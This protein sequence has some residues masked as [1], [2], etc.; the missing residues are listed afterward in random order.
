MANYLTSRNL[1]IAAGI[2]IAFLSGR[3]TAN[4]DSTSAEDPQASEADQRPNSK[5]RATRRNHPKNS[6]HM[7][8]QGAGVASIKT[9]AQLNKILRENG[10]T[11]LGIAQ[12]ALA[13]MNSTELAVLAADLAATYSSDPPHHQ[14]IW[15]TFAQ[16]AKVDPKAALHFSK[17][18]NLPFYRAALRA[19][20]QAFAIDDPISALKEA[21][22]IKDP[23]LA[24]QFKA[25]ALAQMARQAP[26][27]WVTEILSDP[28]N[29]HVVSA[30]SYYIAQWFK[31]DP[32]AALIR[33]KQL[34]PHLLQNAHSQI[35]SAWASKD[36]SAAMEWVSTLTN[37]QTRN[38][39]LTAVVSV[40]AKEQPDKAMELISEMPPGTR[41]TALASI[42]KTMATSDAMGAFN[43][44][45]SLTKSG[46][47]FTALSSILN[48]DG[49][50]FSSSR[51]GSNSGLYIGNHHSMFDMEQLQSI[52]SQLPSGQL[53][54]AALV[55][56]TP[57]LMGSSNEKTNELL[58]QYSDKDRSTIASALIH[59]LYRTDPE[60]ALTISQ[61]YPTTES[62]QNLYSSIIGSIA[63]TDPERAMKLALEGKNFAKRAS[64][65]RSIA[66]GIEPSKMI[67]MLE[68]MGDER[69]RKNLLPTVGSSW[70]RS[71]PNE[72]LQ[73][74]YSLPTG[75]KDRVLQSII[76]S[77]AT[78]DP[79]LATRHFEN[80]VAST[81]Q[82]KTNDSTFNNMANS[83]SSSWSQFDPEAAAEWVNGLSEDKWQQT[84]IT[85][86][87]SGWMEQDLDKTSQWINSFPDGA[88][89]D[90]GVR[91]LVRGLNKSNPSEAYQWA[92]SIS[93]NPQR[94]Y[95]LK[96]VVRKWHRSDPEKARAAI[97]QTKL[98]DKEYD[99]LVK[100][101]S[102]SR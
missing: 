38:Q 29:Q 34:P 22:A 89:R 86:V 32:S 79:Q 21:K 77:L 101:I 24:K 65:L 99:S 37:S 55:Q 13:K 80:M 78:Q 40:L 8:A 27:A 97:D 74:A 62:A 82:D 36:P 10:S 33:I 16:W 30:S 9:A 3:F 2:L 90:S 50:R 53:R 59:N 71:N 7:L 58:S 54:N 75:E 94:I 11:S 20:I 96:E 18:S 49:H 88:T 66:H 14:A 46:D 6:K 91:Q 67:G 61:N 19:S 51:W 12:L 72:A 28:Q 5:F 35:A 41:N 56:M 63:K 98:T 48:P 15:Q 57:H 83:I 23:M 43:K 73:W 44:A 25:S 52:A 31:D 100:I 87:V 68:S 47:R 84:A 69:L 64:H 17:S 45:M 70:A 81:G 95:A 26:D 1:A 60:R 102:P 85:N 42:F 92:N 39:A 76:P 4:Q 93:N